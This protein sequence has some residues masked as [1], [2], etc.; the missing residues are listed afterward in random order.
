[1][2]SLLER[3]FFSKLIR[4]CFVGFSGMI[5][6]FS[7]TFLCKEKIKI[8]KYVSNAI[9][10]LS[11]ASSNYYFN[12][13][14]TFR[15]LNPAIGMEYTKFIFFSII[16]L[17]INTLIIWLLIRKLNMNFYI[18]KLCAIFVV[19]LW[20]FFINLAYTFVSA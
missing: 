1:M 7:L 20:N 8:N 16:G 2:I 6:D 14:W 4:F 9:G 3:T 17:G 12:R 19:T 5:I 10:F 18:S 15:S 13:I 11:A